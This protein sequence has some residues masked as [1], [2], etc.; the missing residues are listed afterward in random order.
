MNILG[1]HTGHDAAACIIKDGKLISAIS[2]ERLTRNKK[3]AMIS[4]KVIE[5]VL[6]HSEN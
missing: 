5:Y 4:T 1:V 6:N 2:T 3:D